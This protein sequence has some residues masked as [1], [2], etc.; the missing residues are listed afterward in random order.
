MHGQGQG[1]GAGVAI[2]IG[3]GVGEGFLGI[4][5]ECQE[6][7]VGRVDGV[8]IGTVRRQH[9]LAISTRQCPGRHRPADH[10]VGTLHVVVEHIAGEDGVQLSGGH[11]VA[12]V[13]G[14]RHVVDDVDVQRVAGGG[15]IAVGDRD[16]ERLAE[17]VDAVGGGMGFVVVEGV[18]VA[19]HAARRVVAGDG[20][21]VA[22]RSG[23]G[24]RE[25]GG[26][27][28]GHH[29]DSAHRQGLHPIQCGD[30]EG[31]AL[32]QCRGAWGRAVAEGSFVDGQF[33]ALDLEAVDQHW[34]VV[35]VNVEHQVGAAA[36]AV[37]VG[38]GVGEG[39][40]DV[41][42]EREKRRIAAVQGVG[43]AAVGGQHQSA[44]ST[45]EGPGSDRPGNDP[46][47]A[48]HVVV[49]HIAGQ[50]RMR[51]GCGN[52][53]AV[54][55][56]VGHIVG[57][58]DVQG[59]AGRITIDVAGDHGEMLTEVV[60]AIPG[61]V[62]FIP[63]QGV[64]VADHAGCRVIADDG[65]GI[66]Q[67]RGDRLWETHRHA[68][69]DDADATNAQALQAIRRGNA[70]GPVLGQGPRVA[71][72]ALGQVGLIQGQ[73]TARH[74]QAGQGDRVVHRQ[75][76]G[77]RQFGIDGRDGGQRV[78]RR[79]RARVIATVLR[80]T[81]Q[82]FRDKF[83]NAVETGCRETDDRVDPP[84]HFFEQDKRV[85]AAG[86]PGGPCAARPGGGGFSDL[87]RVGTGSNG[88]L[89]LLDI[90]QLRLAGRQRFGGVDMR[91]LVGQQLRAQVQAAAAS[92]CQLLTV[93]QV[94]RHRALGPGDQLFTGKQPI[95]FDQGA[96]GSITRHSE[97]LTYD[98]A[99]DCDERCHETSSA[100][101]V[102][103]HLGCAEKACRALPGY[104]RTFC[105]AALALQGAS[106]CLTLIS[107]RVPTQAGW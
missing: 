70:E 46:V 3:Q 33:P 1:C 97:H 98:L 40:G 69:T 82:A 65:Q 103:R 38:Q 61:R 91:R 58:V 4:G 83:G 27:A 52:A 12:V 42:L 99:D 72:R 7:G 94:R 63:H 78:D 11:G 93:L 39:L 44:V 107:P 104:G 15:A 47:G 96:S 68:A 64:A 59:I 45:G 49:Q 89:H 23:E 21:G 75:F 81:R 101:D 22:Q 86:S 28:R 34:I 41:V 25:A 76:R 92:Q 74:R 79:T 48:L 84:R 9:Q 71:G 5:L 36:V 67:G 51:F 106:P 95:P 6:G 8:G 29:V 53:I 37:S 88:L 10:P 30:G 20:Q 50:D 14:L 35:V 102:H 85:T 73:L 87:G 26:D 31:A 16:G 13:L 57:D 32:G 43:V 66:A 105:P 77:H 60:A 90:A 55:E 19:H 54:V 80:R 18:A 100:A 24:L 62:G 2:R 56:R 17:A